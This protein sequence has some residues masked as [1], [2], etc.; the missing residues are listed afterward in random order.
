[1]ARGE[2]G[3]RPPCHG[4]HSRA[5]PAMRTPQLLANTYIMYLSRS[6]RR[7]GWPRPRPRTHRQPPTPGPGRSLGRAIHHLLF[8]HRDIAHRSH[9]WTGLWTP[10]QRALLGPHLRL[11]TL[12]EGQRI[13]L[14][15]CTWAATQ[16]PTLWT[17]FQEHA[18]ALEPLPNLPT[19]LPHAHT[20]YPAQAV[21]D[22]DIPTPDMSARPTRDSTPPPLKRRRLDRPP[23]E[24]PPRTLGSAPTPSASA[25]PQPLP[26]DP[27]TPCS[28]RIPRS[29]WT[30]MEGEDHG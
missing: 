9:L 16:V 1:M 21:S 6:L 22:V 28:P 24:P 17:H 2:P 8:H 25:R 7:T 29:P 19:T 27:I 10:Q 13:L 23:P 18:E 3:R 14:Q 30:S 12:K 26:L 4:R 15:L 5:L 20:D 11:C